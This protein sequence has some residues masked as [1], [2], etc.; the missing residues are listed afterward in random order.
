MSDDPGSEDAGLLFG[1]HPSFL[2][3]GD[4]PWF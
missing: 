2:E 4:D 3:L 1:L